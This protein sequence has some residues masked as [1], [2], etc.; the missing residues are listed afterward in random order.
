MLAKIKHQSAATLNC[1]NDKSI[2]LKT[3]VDLWQSKTS[4]YQ[5]VLHYVVIG[6][7][8]SLLLEEKH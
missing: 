8:Q 2:V 7:W 6:I 1:M 4:R 5:L 3:F